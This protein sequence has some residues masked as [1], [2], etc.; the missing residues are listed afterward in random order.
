MPR[1]ARG[2]RSS[3][4]PKQRDVR[5]YRGSTVITPNLAELA[6]ASALP[7]FDVRRAAAELLPKLE[8]G[9]VARHAQAPTA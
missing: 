3:S 6:A 5:I 2:F 9:R 4:D 8:G 1:A 7:V